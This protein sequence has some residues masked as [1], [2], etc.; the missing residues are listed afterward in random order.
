MLDKIRASL[1]IFRGETELGN[2]NYHAALEQ[3]Q[4]AA[5][6]FGSSISKPHFFNLYLK[7]AECCYV[8]GDM[9][10]GDGALLEARKKIEKS[11]NLS[12]NEKNY[13]LLYAKKLVDS[14]QHAEP[15]RCDVNT[16]GVRKAIL[17]DFPLEGWR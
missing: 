6:L 9:K 1:A 4:N 8:T 7:I 15:D 10:A 5:L 3:F 16:S 12:D 13:L 2:Q 11:R 14:A 17:Q